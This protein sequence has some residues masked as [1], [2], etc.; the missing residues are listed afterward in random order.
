MFGTACVQTWSVL[1]QSIALSSGEAEYYAAGLAAAH[2]IET[3]HML[4]E[5]GIKCRCVVLSDST[6]ALGMCHRLG[7]G[8]VRHMEVRF[9]WLQDIVA[10]KRVELKKV[11]GKANPADVLTKPL[12]HNV[13]RELVQ[14]C[15]LSFERPITGFR[16][17]GGGVGDSTPLPISSRQ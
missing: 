11:H 9:L 2:G 13:V 12:S 14:L 4:E 15:M 16:G 1:Q 7:A 17:V 3:Q 6:A 5:C 8:R 10:K